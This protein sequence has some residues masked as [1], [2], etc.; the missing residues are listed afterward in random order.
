MKKDIEI[1]VPNDWSAVTLKQYLK[2]DRDLEVYGSEEN[3]KTAVLLH[4]LC[5]VEPSLIPKL[6]S[7]ILF[8]IKEDLAGF[9]GQTEFDLKRI[10]NVG[11]KEY[12]FI[13]NL[14]KMEYGAYLD[15]TRY[16]TI[17]IDKNWSKIVSIL[18]RPITSK[19]GK[20]YEIEGYNPETIDEKIFED[21][22]MDVH[23]GA[24]FFFL[25]TLTDL[26][27]DILN[28]LKEE[29]LPLNIRQTLEKNGEV[30]KQLFS[31]RGMTSPNSLLSLRNR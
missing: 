1:N 15:I 28:S 14:S 22:S 29:E 23:F 26:V 3:G 24:Y 13:P 19:R 12:G 2:M 6:P 8:Q 17:T 31:Y 9:M 20:F 25:H 4:H 7:D 16:E 18:Y 30:I 27:N 11:G 10:I 21:I 5:Q